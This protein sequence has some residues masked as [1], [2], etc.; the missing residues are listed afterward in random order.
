MNGSCWFKEKEEFNKK[1]I[2]Q[3]KS[4]RWKAS[5]ANKIIKKKR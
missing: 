1:K 3:L 2:S 5:A 4:I